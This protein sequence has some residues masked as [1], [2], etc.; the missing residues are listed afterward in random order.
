MNEKKTYRAL[1]SQQADIDDG[2]A[3]ISDRHPLTE[4]GHD[5]VNLTSV[6]V[7]GKR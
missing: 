6:Q 3:A 7:A 4:S 2:E 5:V 1:A